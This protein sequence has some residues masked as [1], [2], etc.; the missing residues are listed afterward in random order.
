MSLTND[1]K[2]EGYLFLGQVILDC[3]YA[4][5]GSMSNLRTMLSQSCQTLRSTER[6]AIENHFFL[7]FLLDKFRDEPAVTV[8]AAQAKLTETSKEEHYLS[9]LKSHNLLE[10]CEQLNK[11]GNI[12]LMKNLSQLEDS[13]IIL[14][15]EVLLSKVNGVIFAP[16]GF[17]EHQNVATNTGV[18][19]LS[20]L[21]DLFPNLNSSM[22]IRFLCHLEFCQ[23]ITDSKVLSLLLAENSVCSPSPKSG[24]RYFFFPGLV[25]LSL[26]HIWRCRRSTL[27]RSRWSPYH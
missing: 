7:V 24:E 6:L 9:F 2:L 8:S 3:R 10:I 13:W 20:K 26:I 22:I 27:C 23:E 18:A 12:L 14:D 16:K 1:F 5:S 25:H 17:K 11:R 15:R 21:T 19:L 4:E